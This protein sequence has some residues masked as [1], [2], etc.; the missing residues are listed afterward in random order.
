[1]KKLAIIGASYLQVPLVLKAREMG[2]ETHA[3]A[4][5]E[6]AVAREYSDFFYPISVTEKQQI[7][8]VCKRFNPDGIISIASDIAMPTISY[9][10]ANLNLIAN[11]PDCAFLTTNKYA[12]RNRLKSQG[13]P[14]P[15]YYYLKDSD[16]FDPKTFHAIQYPMIVKPTDRSGSRGVQKVTNAKELKAAIPRAMHESFSKETII[17]KFIDGREISVEMISWKGNH[18]FMAATDKVTTGPPY[19]VEIEHHQPAALSGSLLK[20]IIKIVKK[21]L[22]ALEVEYG[23]SHSEL[24]ITANDEI[25]VVEIGARMGGDLIGSDLV[26]I[27]TGYD[28]VK[29]VIDVAMGN[30]EPPRKTRNTFSGVYF[31]SQET[32]YLMDLFDEK[33]R[34]FIVAKELFSNPL[35]KL[36]NSSD[37]SGYLI[38]SAERKITFS[39]GKPFEL[40]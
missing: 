16:F 21:A 14:C 5:E 33:T 27:S 2:I 17:E 37:R 39:N 8:E 34:P 26:L 1:M 36:T 24:I 15:A 4:W 29:G 40:Y 35:S 3:F 9:V 18:Y 22:S 10:A 12:M 7:L 32:S 38:Y 19:F 25:F 30:F 20:N 11:S 13:L 28:F 6:G 31:L 23:A